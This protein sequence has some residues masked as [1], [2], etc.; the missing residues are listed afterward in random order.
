MGLFSKKT[1]V[2]RD[3]VSD[4]KKFDKKLKKRRKA[5]KVTRQKRKINRK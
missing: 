3:Y 4:K 5:N 2:G 1:Y